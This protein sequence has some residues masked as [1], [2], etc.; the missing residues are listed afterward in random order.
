[1]QQH[2]ARG[3]F[4]G[5]ILWPRPESEVEISG[6]K[7]TERDVIV[8]YNLIQ[9]SS[10]RLRAFR[11]PERPHVVRRELAHFVIALKL[12]S[13]LEGVT[14]VMQQCACS[15]MDLRTAT[16]RTRAL[17]ARFQVSGI[18]TRRLRR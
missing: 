5:L 7:V 9:A 16:S 8:A 6:V 11:G 10:R 4:C 15:H 3:R 12:A 1:M 18:S 17:P 2:L 14:R 13:S